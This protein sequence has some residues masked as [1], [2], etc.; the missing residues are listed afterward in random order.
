MYSLTKAGTHLVDIKDFT[1]FAQS[2]RSSLHQIVLHLRLCVLISP[3]HLSLPE[4]LLLCGRGSP[5]VVSSACDIA[6]AA[7]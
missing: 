2:L 5:V 1:A 4:M 6:P 7:R 3:R